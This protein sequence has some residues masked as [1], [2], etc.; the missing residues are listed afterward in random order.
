MT[1]LF[2]ILILWLLSILNRHSTSTHKYLTY[3]QSKT[4]MHNSLNIHSAKKHKIQK[5]QLHISWETGWLDIFYY[6]NFD[7]FV[8]I[9]PD[10]VSIDI[11][12]LVIPK[13]FMSKSC[14]IMNQT[15]N[16]KCII[17]TPS[18]KFSYLTVSLFGSL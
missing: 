16:K 8:V 12:K 10:Q 4:Q 5:G 2:F 9:S 7:L 6:T 1:P 18:N 13:V 17:T 3:I 14:R 11:L 15:S